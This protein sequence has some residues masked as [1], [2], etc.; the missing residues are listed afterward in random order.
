MKHTEASNI[1]KRLL[2]EFQIKISFLAL[3]LDVSE[4]TIRNYESGSTEPKEPMMK[5][6]RSILHHQEAERKK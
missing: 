3:K 2:N 6:L 1:I 5:I 4:A